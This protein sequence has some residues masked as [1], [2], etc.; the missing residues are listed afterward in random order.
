MSVQEIQAEELKRRLDAG[1]DVFL[2]DVRE[3]DNYATTNIEGHSIPLP[4]LP[5]RLNELDST[6][7]IVTI[8]KRRVRG[9]EA[10]ALTANSGYV[11]YSPHRDKWVAHYCPAKSQRYGLPFCAYQQ[12]RLPTFPLPISSQFDLFA[13]RS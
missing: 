1:E 12:A 5:E 7:E 13:L 3:K 9:I 11:L 4:Q 10:A 8:C 2:L 6:Q